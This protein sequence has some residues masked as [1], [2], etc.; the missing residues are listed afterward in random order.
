MQTFDVTRALPRRTASIHTQRAYYRWID[1]FLA[2][3]TR[4][5]RTRGKARLKRM[6]TLSLSMLENHL[7]PQKLSAWLNILADN[8]QSR[9]GLDQARA[10]LVTL[11]DLLADDDLLHP[12]K[13]AAIRD[14]SVPAVERKS[15]PERLLTPDEIRQIIHA[16]R[17]M[18]TSHNQ[19]LRNHVIALMLCTMALRR[20]ELST[21]TWADL[22]LH[23]GHVMLEMN[24]GEFVDVPRPVLNMADKWREAIDNPPA[25]S[26]LIRRIWKGGRIAKAGLSPDGIWLIIR[27]AAKHAG[28]G[29]VTPDDLRRSAVANMYRNGLPIEEIQRVL[30]H[31]SRTVTERFLARLPVEPDNTTD[32]P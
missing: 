12:D 18:A 10:A 1:R 20:E 22:H 27:N 7:T 19:M 16:A 11:A 9:Q 32:K 21:V 30:R 29:H 17:D 23:E 13:A 14:V 25:H 28:L 15:T 5:K 31:R 26:P 3:V 8:G 6:Q 4:K 24:A 2:D